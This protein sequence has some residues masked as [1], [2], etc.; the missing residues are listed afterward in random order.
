LGPH[1]CD[2]QGKPEVRLDKL[3]NDSA[4][5]G[6]SNIN[7]FSNTLLSGMRGIRVDDVGFG[8][9]EYYGLPKLHSGE[10]VAVWKSSP[11]GYPT[12]PQLNAENNWW[13]HPS[14]PKEIR[15]IPQ[16]R[17]DLIIDLEQNVALLHG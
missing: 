11:G 8:F 6:N 3:R 1:W 2:D 5:G 4:V 15:E 7:I 10:L 13:G 17:A 16:E 12:T 14:G 9:N